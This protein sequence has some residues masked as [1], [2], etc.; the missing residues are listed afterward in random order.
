MIFHGVLKKLKHIRFCSTSEIYSSNTH[1]IIYIL[2]IVWMYK[3]HKTLWIHCTHTALYWEFP[4]IHWLI[5]LFINK[6]IC[7]WIYE[8]HFFVICIN[9]ILSSHC[10]TD[11]TVFGSIKVFSSLSLFVLCAMFEDFQ[12]FTTE[13][14]W[15]KHSECLIRIMRHPNTPV[16]SY[17]CLVF[18]ATCFLPRVRFTSRARY[19]FSFLRF[20]L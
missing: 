5:I 18:L 17:L 15:I 9:V 8:L 16:Q 6:L 3:M 13:Y 19:L 11:L 10:L 2:Y 20:L 1:I 12:H 4:V 14:F 7:L